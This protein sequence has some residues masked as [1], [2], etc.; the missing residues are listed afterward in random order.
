MRVIACLTHLPNIIHSDSATDSLSGR[1]WKTLRRRMRA[2]HND[3]LVLA[4]GNEADTTM[5][6]NEIALRAKE[7]TIGIP[8]DTRQAYKDGTNGFE[9]VLPGA[10]RMYPDTDLPPLEIAQSR[11]DRIRAG[12][13]EPIWE[14]EARYAKLRL[15]EETRRRLAISPL[16]PLFDRLVGELGLDATFVAVVLMQWLRHL[17]RERRSSVGP[18]CPTTGHGSEPACSMP[19][20]SVGPPRPTTSHPGHVGVLPGV[21]PSV[22]PAVKASMMPSVISAALTDDE[23]FA[24]FEAHKRN[25]LSREGVARVLRLVAEHAPVAGSTGP[26]RGG[27]LRGAQLHAP[28]RRR[29]RRSHLPPPRP[30]RQQPLPD[31]H[32]KMPLSLRRHAP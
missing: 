22:M 25:L 30:P 11:L 27:R 20:R 29:V 19:L 4:W 23:T 32:P 9:R 16:A 21:S 31:C 13:P 24:V 7:A 10:E 5:A 26:A 6:A 14:R 18:P 1:E 2:D 8:S 3:A 15:P 28:L 12:V 17:E